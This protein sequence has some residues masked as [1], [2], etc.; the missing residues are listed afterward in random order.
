MIEYQFS[1]PSDSHQS[2]I[3]SF[4][5]VFIPSYQLTTTYTLHLTSYEGYEPVTF[6]GRTSINITVLENDNPYGVFQFDANTPIHAGSK[7]T[8]TINMLTRFE[9]IFH[10][11]LD[12]VIFRYIILNTFYDKDLSHFMPKAFIIQ[13]IV[14]GKQP[15]VDVI[16]LCHY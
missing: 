10:F 12:Y 13:N 5:Y 9:Q 15:L 16:F 1:S 6:T 3:S 7:S 2:I 4:L 11:S 8:Y 14:D